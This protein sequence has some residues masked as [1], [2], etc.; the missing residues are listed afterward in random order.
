M[1]RIFKIPAIA[2]FVILI[3]SNAAAQQKLSLA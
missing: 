3:G 2:L 1:K